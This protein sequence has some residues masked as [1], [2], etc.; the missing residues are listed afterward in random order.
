MI[1]F[2]IIVIFIFISLLKYNRIENFSLPIFNNNYDKSWLMPYKSLNS[3]NVQDIPNKEY[4]NH[5]KFNI[6][7]N[8]EYT[9][10]LNNLFSKYIIKN[11][12]KKTLK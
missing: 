12:D 9:E 1:I 6:V 8:I 4:I 3:T 2:I 10:S 5:S 11:K 7:K